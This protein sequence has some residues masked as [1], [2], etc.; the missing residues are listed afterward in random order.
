MHEAWFAQNHHTAAHPNQNGQQDTAVPTQLRTKHPTTAQNIAHN[1]RT[2][3]NRTPSTPTQTSTNT[4]A[5]QTIVPRLKQH[6]QRRCS[7]QQHQRV[8][9]D[10]FQKSRRQPAQDTLSAQKHLPTHTQPLRKQATAITWPWIL[11]P[12]HL[13]APLLSTAQE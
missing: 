7:N 13:T 2:P 10:R 5:S 9:V 6:S 8:R 4:H 1:N 3:R 12:Q 11:N